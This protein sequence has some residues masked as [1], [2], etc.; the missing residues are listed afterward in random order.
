MTPLAQI[1]DL[2]DLLS[3]IWTSL[4][5]GI[6]VCL[7]FSLAIIGF[8]RATDTS[9]EGQ[10]VA[11]VAWAALALVA[12]AAVLALVVFGVVVMTSK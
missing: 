2:G 5:A 8:A 12:F 6:G 1:L 3:V 7:V 11:T 10:S 4:A 9:R